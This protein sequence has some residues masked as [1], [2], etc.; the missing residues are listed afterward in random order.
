MKLNE[1]EIPRGA[2]RQPKRVGRGQGSGHGKT[3][4]RGHKGLKSRSG[5]GGKLRIGFEGGQMPLIRRVPKRGFTSKFK[6]RYQIVNVDSL[7]LFNND[8]T[9]TPKELRESGLIRYARRPVKILGNGALD[10]K[11][12]VT[13][14][15]VSASAKEKIEKAGG[16]VKNIDIPAR[17]RNRKKESA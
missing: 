15:S 8:D 13:A 14:H 12:A 6:I 2:R 5:A 7:N 4:C 11:I 10:K 3:S 1:L 9:V 16:S 17:R